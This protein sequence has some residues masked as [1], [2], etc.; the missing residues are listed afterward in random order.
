MFF[1]HGFAIP[2]RC[3]LRFPP[4]EAAFP[5]GMR[6]SAPLPCHFTK[7]PQKTPETINIFRFFCYKKN[8]FGM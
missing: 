6:I 4:Q 3:A 7:A 5:P 8:E 2:G 1:K